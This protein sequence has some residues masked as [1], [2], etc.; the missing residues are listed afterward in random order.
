MATQLIHAPQ[1]I[2]DA[3][4]SLQRTWFPDL[5]GRPRITFDQVPAG[6]SDAVAVVVHDP[7]LSWDHWPLHGS[8][9]FVLLLTSQRN[10]DREYL[11]R[12]L[13]DDLLVPLIE[14]VMEGLHGRLEGHDAL[15]LYSILD[16]AR[17]QPN[18][19]PLPPLVR[20][21]RNRYER[22][23]RET[24]LILQRR[25]APA[26]DDLQEAIVIYGDMLLQTGLGQ[27]I[28][29]L[30]TEGALADRLSLKPGAA[31]GC[32]EPERNDPVSIASL[33]DEI[34]QARGVRNAVNWVLEELAPY[35]LRSRYDL[36]AFHVAQI[37][38]HAFTDIGPHHQSP[39]WR[40]KDPKST[41]FPFAVP[42]VGIEQVMLRFAAA[43]DQRLLADVHPLI[44]GVLALHHLLRI[45]PFGRCDRNVGELLLHVL[46]R[47]GGLPPMPL[48]LVGYRLYWEHAHMIA[49]AAE[50]NQC[51]CLVETMIAAVWDGIMLGWQMAA[52]LREERRRLL[53]ALEESD[54]LSED[55]AALVSRLLSTVIEEPGMAEALRLEP[56]LD[57]LHAKG[58]IDKI[59]VGGKTCWSSG[60]SRQLAAW[61]PT[62][63]GG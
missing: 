39:L 27:I 26:L 52:P 13:P 33:Q 32:L 22:R 37:Y 12:V 31:E 53:D 4:L 47:Q 63:R 56:T 2:I 45:A 51:D 62:K 28:G 58:L 60:I 21:P 18:A 1:H 8:E 35:T 49:V 54:M 36:S 59:V 30:S 17:D 20:R 19:L 38:R 61:Q 3:F 15:E 48:L 24:A 40:R 9:V 41:E 6:Q 23:L 50:Q 46:M 14:S 5:D 43:F 16:A 42:A 34:G 7:E 55:S 44:K 29:D 10:P 11:P 57:H 25:F